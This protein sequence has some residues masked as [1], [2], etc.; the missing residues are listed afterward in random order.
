MYVGPVSI[1]TIDG[2]D[3]GEGSVVSWHATQESLAKAKEA[4]VSSVPAS[5]MQAQHLRGYFEQTAKGLDYSRLLIV[6]C[7]FPGR[8]DTRAMTYVINAHL[9]RHDTYRSWFEYTGSH[10]IVRRTIADPADIEFAPTKHGVLAAEE[11]RELLA[12]TPDPLQWDCFT[13]GIVQ[14]T[15]HF[16]L[17]V[18]ID[19][20]HMDAMFVGVT[21]MEFLFMYTTLI[22]GAPPLALPEAGSYD[23]FCRR[24]DRFISQLTPD[25]PAVRVWTEYAEANQG[26][27]P[28]FPLPLGDTSKPC[29]AAVLTETLLDA[30]QTVDFEAAC[31]AS[32]ARFVGGVLACV[33]LTNREFT[34]ADTYYGLTPSDTRSSTADQM[35]L[36]W[37]TGL[38][39]ITV[40]LGDG[41]F[42]PAARAAQESF[43]GGRDMVE[44]PFY[45]V[46][47]LVPSLR[48]PRPNFPVVNYLD[49]GAPPLSVLLTTQ[50]EG[51][52][53]GIFADGRY[54]YQMTV[55]VI[56]L[57]KETAVTVVYPD[58][59]TARASAETYVAALRSVSARAAAVPA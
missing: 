48:W 21:L 8:C 41:A 22:S 10:G 32:G 38:V 36:G 49:A 30:R 51:M 9:R 27:F 40:P 13:F 24:Q 55:F 19:H 23:E 12:D 6:T 33:G 35:T 56:R 47:E 37:F 16:T 58:N 26:S 52:N 43:D 45:R 54:S 3:P 4:P 44:V 59:P 17:Y 14:H 25:T 29:T 15:T 7:D 34:G 57:G 53:I 2:W 50:L 31:V 46:L 42:G 11:L 28:D 1:G 5:Y 20:L 18:S 39:P